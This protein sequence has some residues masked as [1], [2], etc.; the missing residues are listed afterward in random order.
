MEEV[1]FE[2]ENTFQQSLNKRPKR[3]TFFTRL[4][5]RA[6]IIKDASK[7]Q[8]AI[9]IISIVFI[10]LATALYYFTSSE[11]EIVADPYIEGG[12]VFVDQ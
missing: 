3:R 4:L 2:E 7:A 5:L 10:V 1:K 11:E 6:G 9:F 8:R 12:S